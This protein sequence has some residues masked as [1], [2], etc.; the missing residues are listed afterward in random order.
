MNGRCEVVGGEPVELPK[1]LQGWYDG[2][3]SVTLPSGRV[4]TPGQYR[5]LKWN[6]DRYTTPVVQFPNGRYAVDQYWWGSTARYVGGLRTPGFHHVNLTVNR[7]FNLMER[8]RLELIG[9][10]TN[11]FNRTNFNPNAVTGGYSAVL[12]AAPATNTKVG[13]N[14]TVNHGS[15]GL[16]VFEPRQ[17]TLSLRLR[18]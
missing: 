5:Y 18:F 14:S 12:V 1:A 7:Q 11:L 6:P 4:I 13:Q 10:A 9:E 16:S 17:V 8:L 15:L 3:T 2:K